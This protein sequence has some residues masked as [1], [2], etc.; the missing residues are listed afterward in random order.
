MATGHE[1]RLAAH[2]AAQHPA[3]LLVA[4][5]QRCMR[6]S[7]GA[8]FDEP[9]HQFRFRHADARQ[10]GDHAKMRGDA[11][12]ARMADAVAIDEHQVRR[13]WQQCQCG[14]QC[15]QLAEAEQAR[16]IGHQCGNPRDLLRHGLQRLCIQQHRRGAGN[17]TVVLEADVQPGQPAHVTGQAVLAFHAGGQLQLLRAGSGD[18]A[19]P[20]PGIDHRIHGSQ[21]RTGGATAR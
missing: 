5:Q 12:P 20:A 1:Q 3:Q 15:R 18:A 21:H 4:I 11:K 7:F 9:S 6:T 16:D 19:F 2:L 10:I 17:G 13:S 8:R 14:Q